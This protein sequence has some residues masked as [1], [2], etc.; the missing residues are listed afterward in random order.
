MKY[1]YIR[2]YRK[3]VQD[4]SWDAYKNH[5]HAELS[6]DGDVLKFY[7]VK[8]PDVK[9]LTELRLLKKGIQRVIDVGNYEQQLMNDILYEVGY[10]KEDCKEDNREEE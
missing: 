1:G 9:E 3:E 8:E 2:I 6:E 10:Y 4:E 7:T 5:P